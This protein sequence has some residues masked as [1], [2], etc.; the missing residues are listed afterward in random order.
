MLSVLE[1]RPDVAVRVDDDR[2]E[3]VD[4]YEDDRQREED[5]EDGRED[6][7]VFENLGEVEIAE[8]DAEKRRP[9][10]ALHGTLQI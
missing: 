1:R 6:T 5:D 7:V 2:E 3:H 10:G 9:A 4:E 8:H